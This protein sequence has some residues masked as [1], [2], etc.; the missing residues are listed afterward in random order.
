M[1]I[2][3]SKQIESDK[4]NESISNIEYLARE[5]VDN[6]DDENTTFENKELHEAVIQELKRRALI[7]LRAYID[8]KHDSKNLRNALK[9]HNITST[10]KDNILK[11]LMKKDYTTVRA[12]IADVI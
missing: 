8:A 10:T 9:K 3:H 2:L 7:Q 11:S 1:D 6:G 12:V 4:K 5:R